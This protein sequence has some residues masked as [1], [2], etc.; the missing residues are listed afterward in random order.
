MIYGLA[1]DTAEHEARHRAAGRAV[2]GWNVYKLGGRRR[3][4]R[5]DRQLQL[6]H[7]HG[8][9]QAELVAAAVDEAAAARAE[10]FHNY[11]VTR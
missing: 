2:V 11:G 3:A 9:G 5:K 7:D 1:S 6:A 10:R 4:A 8:M